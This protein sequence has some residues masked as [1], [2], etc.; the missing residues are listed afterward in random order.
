MIELFSDPFF[1]PQARLFCVTTVSIVVA[2][3]GVSVP[4]VKRLEAADGLLGG[5]EDTGH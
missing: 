5:R 2:M 3:A 1:L 4:T